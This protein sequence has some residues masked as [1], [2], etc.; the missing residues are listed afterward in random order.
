MPG[1]DKAWRC[2]IAVKTLL[3]DVVSPPEG[4]NEACT[5]LTDRLH[6]FN[7]FYV[8]VRSEA[9]H[10]KLSLKQRNKDEKQLIIILMIN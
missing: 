3:L 9:T 8:C 2:V 4:R 7:L 5:I 1:V 10:R 6:H